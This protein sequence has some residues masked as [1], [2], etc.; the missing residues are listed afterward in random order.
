MARQIGPETAIKLAQVWDKSRS[1]PH[2]FELAGVETKNKRNQQKYRRQA[3]EIL[4]YRLPSKSECQHKPPLAELIHLD[5]EYTI[6]IFSD[7]HFWPDE[8]SEAFWIL[9]DILKD[10]QPEFVINGGDAF[11]GAT[12]SRH[13]AI[14]W[15]VRPTLA[16]EYEAVKTHLEMIKEASGDASLYWVEGNHDKRFENFLVSKAAQLQDMPGSTLEGLFPDWTMCDSLFA[17]DVIHIKHRWHSGVHAAYNNTLKCGKS[18]ATGHTHRLTCREWTDLNGTRYG[19]ECGTLAN[20]YGPQFRYTEDNCVDWRMGFVI[21]TLDS[22]GIHPELVEVK[23][24]QARFRGRV[25]K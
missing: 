8:T 15:E 1:M 17:N 24:G 21:L 5:H 2:A 13:P 6:V 14:G 7:A 25:Y 4:G 3:E 20:P 22:N 16:D 10:V 9:L 19:I 18:I 23:N 11:D 12:I